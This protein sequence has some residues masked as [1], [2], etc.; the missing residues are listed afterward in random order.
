MKH[1][2]IF[3]YIISFLMGVSGIT[4]AVLLAKRFEDELYK[5]LRAFVVTFFLYE[6]TNFIAIY[7]S[8]FDL[9]WETNII[10]A[11]FTDICSV[12]LLYAWVGLIGK[13]ARVEVKNRLFDKSLKLFSVMYVLIGLFTFLYGMDQNYNLTIWGKVLDISIDSILLSFA[14]WGSVFYLVKG[15]KVADQVTKKVL[16]VLSVALYLFILL[17]SYEELDLYFDFWDSYIDAYFFDPIVVIYL[18]LNVLFIIYVFKE[19]LLIKARKTDEAF[20]PEWTD[21]GRPSIED[22]GAQYSLTDREKEVLLMVYEGHSN[23]KI[24]DMLC[25]SPFTVKRHLNNIFRKTAVKNR[26]ELM[27]L[28]ITAK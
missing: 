25:I 3:F 11:F 5:W 8:F 7:S 22:I 24:A 20:G 18:L 16:L 4:L 19:D 15:L 26:V 9:H 13:V 17:F 10:L 28:V 12:A 14:I 21:K 27:H 6:V 2:I 23:L 1:V